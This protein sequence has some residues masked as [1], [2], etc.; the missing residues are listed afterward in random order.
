M[1][2]IIDGISLWAVLIST[3]LLLIGLNMTITE[4][5]EYG[6]KKQYAKINY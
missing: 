1:K 2:Y 6:N 3:Y 4:K 5:K